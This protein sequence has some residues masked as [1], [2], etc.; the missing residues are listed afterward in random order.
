M[1]EKNNLNPETWSLISNQAKF[2]VTWRQYAK[3]CGRTTNGHQSSEPNAP[4]AAANGEKRSSN[5]TDTSILQPQE[6][7]QKNNDTESL[8]DKMKHTRN[9]CNSHFKFQIYINHARILEFRWL[10][11]NVPKTQ[12][13]SLIASIPVWFTKLYH[14]AEN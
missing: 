9:N 12:P 13:S 6:E 1:L 7:K 3:N 8:Q 5:V 2:S 10:Q 11:P 14:E 4:C